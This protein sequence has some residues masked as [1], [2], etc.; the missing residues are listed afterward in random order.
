MGTR[1]MLER[2]VGEAPE[3]KPFALHSCH[4]PPC[5]NYRHLRWGSFAENQR[6]RVENGTDM[7]GEKCPRAKLKT[8]EV[9][10][11]RED[12]RQAI[13]I[14]NDYGVSDR[15]I[16]SIKNRNTWAWL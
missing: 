3:D 7:R 10:R 16:Y 9:L 13:S 1:L 5:F 8:E 15:T 2:T 12:P 11:I 14:A 4:N 6:D